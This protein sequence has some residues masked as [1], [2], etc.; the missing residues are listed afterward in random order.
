MRSAVLLAEGVSGGAA[1]IKRTV[2]RVAPAVDEVVV[3]CRSGQQAAIE[4]ALADEP[5]RLAMD[6][7]LGRSPVAG[8]RSGCRVARGSETFVTTCDDDNV[9]P[10]LITRLFDACGLDGAVPR[11]DGE[12]RPLA[13]VYDTE[14]A[15]AAADVTLGMGSA[16]VTEMLDRLAVQIVPI[17]SVPE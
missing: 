13:A 4:T 14:A 2:E 11:I 10:A 6:P 9:R 15:V 8:V 7:V 3:S 16:S 17:P 5:Y 12:N 1:P